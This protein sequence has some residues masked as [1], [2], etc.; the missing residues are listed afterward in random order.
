VLKQELTEEEHNE[1]ELK[2][3]IATLEDQVKG[4]TKRSA[5]LQQDLDGKTAEVSDQASKDAALNKQVEELTSQIHV[6]EAQNKT[7]TTEVAEAKMYAGTTPSKNA[8]TSEENS[9]PSHKAE[10]LSDKV[11]DVADMKKE[12]PPEHGPTVSNFALLNLNWYVKA[13]GVALL[14]IAVTTCIL[15]KCGAFSGCCKKHVYA[16]ASTEELMLETEPLTPS[17][18]NEIDVSYADI[19]NADTDELMMAQENHDKDL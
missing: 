6:L 5:D 14:V 19:D 7:L 9:P 2:Q 10:K 4:L 8:P 12:N 3:R 11:A 1:V 16:S 13:G 17:V 18:S 15:C